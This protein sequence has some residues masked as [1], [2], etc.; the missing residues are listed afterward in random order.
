[1]QTPVTQGVTLQ[2]R[3]LGRF[4]IRWPLPRPTD[5]EKL[6]RRR[7]SNA[8]VYLIIVDSVPVWA[9]LSVGRGMSYLVESPSVS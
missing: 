2:N 9:R 4:L 5:F 6:P 8:E 7:T 1:M 3:V